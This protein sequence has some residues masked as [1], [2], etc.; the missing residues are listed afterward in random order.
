MQIRE[1]QE[2]YQEIA[3]LIPAVETASNAEKIIG[4]YTS[5]IEQEGKWEKLKQWIEYL[6]Q[7][8]VLQAVLAINKLKRTTEER[9]RE[10]KEILIFEIN[11]Q[12][13]DEN[14]FYQLMLTLLYLNEFD[15]ASELYEQIKSFE[16]MNVKVDKIETKIQTS[17]NIIALTKLVKFYL[18]EKRKPQIALLLR[19]NKLLNKFYSY[20]LNIL[21]EEE[22]KECN[23]ICKELDILIEENA[24]LLEKLNIKK[25]GKKYKIR[26]GYEENLLPTIQFLEF[27]LY[28][29]IKKRKKI[30]TEE[31]SNLLFL[32]MEIE[33]TI[34]KL[35]NIYQKK[36]ELIA[37]IVEEC[38]KTEEYYAD[39]LM[40][41]IEKLNEENKNIVNLLNEKVSSLEIPT[42]T[43]V[44]YKRISEVIYNEICSYKMIPVKVIFE[45]WIGF[46]DYFLDMVKEI[47]SEEEIRKNTK[48]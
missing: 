6:A 7:K 40:K 48:I 8:D 30:K 15:K 3:K 45:K 14:R 18:N 29:L 47:K 27:I 44:K 38:G 10:L 42:K 23:N 22:L 21:N 36:I 5:K 25:S 4:F 43:L 12:I 31:L 20:V 17:D 28:K 1:L 11:N 13:N 37:N 16:K 41:L 32:T 26:V 35:S 39:K 46:C 34:F 19:E 2:K 33:K 24:E 9:K